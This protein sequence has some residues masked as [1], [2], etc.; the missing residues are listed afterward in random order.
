MAVAGSRKSARLRMARYYG[1]LRLNPSHPKRDD[2]DLAVS[3][4]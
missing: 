4:Q 2:K 3:S 1:P